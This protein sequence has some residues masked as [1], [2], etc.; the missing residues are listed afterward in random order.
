MSKVQ[1]NE[2]MILVVYETQNITLQEKI[3]LY[4]NMKNIHRH[5]RSSVVMNLYKKDLKFFRKSEALIKLG[6]NSYHN[7]MNK[8]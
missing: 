6:S 8:T 5:F 7:K 3:C 1:L 2:A 4:E